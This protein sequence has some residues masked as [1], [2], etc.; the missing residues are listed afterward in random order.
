MT[1]KSKAFCEHFVRPKVN[2]VKRVELKRCVKG[3]V[4]RGGSGAGVDIS[5]R[6]I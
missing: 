1:F 6:L 4:L 2:D 3:M 5:P